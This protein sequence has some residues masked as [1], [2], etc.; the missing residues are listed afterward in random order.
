MIFTKIDGNIKEREDLGH[1]H[2]ETAMVKSDDLAKSILRVK[3][4]H[5]NEYGIRL[6]EG[7][8]EN[9]SFFFIDDHH[10]LVLNVIP[11]EMIVITPK[12]IDDCGII[13]L[14]ANVSELN[15]ILPLSVVYFRLVRISV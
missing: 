3:S 11:E 15:H 5:H 8:L 14:F 4:D 13:E 10:V 1:V 9:G 2:V 12:D 7:K 6:E